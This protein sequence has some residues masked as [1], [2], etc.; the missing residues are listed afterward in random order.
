[1]KKLLPLLTL[2]L[3]LATQAFAQIQRND[4]ITIG[5]RDLAGAIQP[6]SAEQTFS[7]SIPDTLNFYRRHF[8]ATG[9]RQPGG[10]FNSLCTSPTRMIARLDRRYL[11][12]FQFVLV[13]NGLENLSVPNI[14]RVTTMTSNVEFTYNFPAKLEVR[15]KDGVLLRTFILSPEH[16]EHRVTIGPNFLDDA[17]SGGVRPPASTFSPGH[18]SITSWVDRHE[19]RILERMEWNGID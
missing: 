19:S 14:V 17:L 3:L 11:A 13:T 1:M 15:N 16:E 8:L 5:S 7:L 6:L 4:I 9:A 12:D 10:V 18:G 2:M